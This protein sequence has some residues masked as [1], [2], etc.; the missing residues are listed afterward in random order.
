MKVTVETLLTQE[1]EVPEDWGREQV[2]EWLA[3]NQS[4]GDAFV[5]ISDVNQ[6]ARLTAIQVVEERV[7]ELGKEAYDE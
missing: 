5:G 6:V 7:T 2:F 1:L 4:F 3:I